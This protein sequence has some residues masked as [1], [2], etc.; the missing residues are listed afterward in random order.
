[1]GG[2]AYRYLQ[3]IKKGSEGG[4]EPGNLFGSGVQGYLASHLLFG[5]RATIVKSRTAGSSVVAWLLNS[6][7]DV[8]C[9]GFLLLVPPRELVGF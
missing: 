6:K 7:Y 3:P 1:M 2:D 9:K 8:P 4:L 5:G